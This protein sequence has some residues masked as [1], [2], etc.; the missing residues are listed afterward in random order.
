M[1]DYPVVYR[2]ALNMTFA[3]VL[4]RSDE[5]PGCP[6]WFP[7]LRDEMGGKALTLPGVYTRECDGVAACDRVVIC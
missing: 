3:V 5:F 1:T 2:R 7:E 6:L 4:L